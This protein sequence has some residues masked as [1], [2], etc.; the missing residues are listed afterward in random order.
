MLLIECVLI[1]EQFKIP[2]WILSRI[3]SYD[4]VSLL[5][6][7]YPAFMNGCRCIVGSFVVNHKNRR[8]EALLE[9]SE[10]SRLIAGK[11]A[12]II[13]GTEGIAQAII[14]GG[15]SSDS[16]A[17][18]RGA[19]SGSM[20]D[21]LRSIHRNSLHDSIVSGVQLKAN[22]ILDPVLL[23]RQNKAQTDYSWLRNMLVYLAA[24]IVIS[25]TSSGRK[26]A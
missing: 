15:S 21:S 19:E 14:D 13:Q 18:R 12:L 17:S 16:A 25:K 24:K 4:V 26:S 10:S 8:V 20:A 9:L 11:A 1:L 23:S 7:L 22:M 3:T 2:V 6:R 5:H